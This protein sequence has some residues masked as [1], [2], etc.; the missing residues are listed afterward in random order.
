MRTDI[1]FKREIDSDYS[2]SRKE[3]KEARGSFK[4]KFLFLRVARR[5]C[6]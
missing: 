5:V 6:G 2:L 4:K 1:F 3:Q